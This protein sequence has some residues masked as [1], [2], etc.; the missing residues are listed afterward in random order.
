MTTVQIRRCTTIAF[1]AFVLASIAATMNI[2]LWRL[3]REYV[4]IMLVMVALAAVVSLASTVIS[5]YLV[6]RQQ[7]LWLVIMA[8]AFAL[9][10]WAA[11]TSWGWVLFAARQSRISSH[12]GNPTV[13]SAWSGVEVA[14]IVPAVS[15]AVAA[16]ATGVA[17]VAMASPYLQRSRNHAGYPPAG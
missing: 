14:A 13:A 7:R 4:F 17:L 15:L 2:V 11:W 16:A 10:L 9:S 12:V 5:Q 3:Q 8:I 6:L 1:A